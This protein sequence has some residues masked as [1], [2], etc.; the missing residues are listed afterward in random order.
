V[1]EINVSRDMPLLASL[2]VTA[3][4]MSFEDIQSDLKKETYHYDTPEAF[5][6]YERAKAAQE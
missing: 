3:S 5:I 1:T 6:P 4:Q 2:L